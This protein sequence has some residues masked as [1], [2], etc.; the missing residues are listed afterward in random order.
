MIHLRMNA[1]RTRKRQAAMRNVF[2]TD[3]TNFSDLSSVS[4]DEEDGGVEQNQQTLDGSSSEHTER[5]GNNVPGQYEDYVPV[6][7]D[8]SDIDV[9]ATLPMLVQDDTHVDASAV[10]VIYPVL[11]PVVQSLA[12][13]IP[14]V[15]TADEPVG[16]ASLSSTTESTSMQPYDQYALAIESQRP[17]SPSATIVPPGGDEPDPGTTPMDS[18]FSV[19]ASRSPIT[20]PTKDATDHAGALDGS[21]A[22]IPTLP[23]VSPTSA[24]RDARSPSASVESSSVVAP[25]KLFS[26]PSTSDEGT[27][28]GSLSSAPKSLWTNAWKINLG[29]LVGN[30]SAASS[31]SLHI[32]S[33]SS[34]RQSGHPVLANQPS[35]AAPK[36]LSAL[37]GTTS[38]DEFRKLSSGQRGSLPVRGVQPSNH[39]SVPDAQ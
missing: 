16:A 38:L 35:N 17:A 13:G 2:L 36:K 25:P 32:G 3:M 18:V 19:T 28:S 10:D 26:A 4:G 29:S 31:S 6:R 27:G 11:H 22:A 39:V 37:A 8:S 34:P 23:I 33:A 30:A 9:D 12:S 1:Q 5:T 20:L 14:G 21:S 24:A 7:P 15:V